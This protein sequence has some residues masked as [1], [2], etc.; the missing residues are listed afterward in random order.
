MIKRKG[1]GRLSKLKGGFGR[2][3]TLV[4]FSLEWSGGEE[5]GRV[6]LW[7]GESD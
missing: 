5:R 7:K 2:G 1:G 6:S 3:R 4:R